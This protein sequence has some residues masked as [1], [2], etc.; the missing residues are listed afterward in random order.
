MYAWDYIQ[1][2][3]VSI[4]AKKNCLLVSLGDEFESGTTRPRIRVDVAQTS[5]FE[6]REFRTFKEWPTATSG[7]YVIKVVVP[8]N[9]ILH[10]LNIDA[11]EG[12]LRMLTK[13][14]GSEGGSFDEVFPIFSTN[15]MSE[16]PQ[17]P[18]AAQCSLVAGGTHTG[19]TVLDPLRVK[20]SGNTNFASSAGARAAERGIGAG[21]YYFAITLTNF[22]GTLK[23]RWEERP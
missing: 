12:S 1:K 15:T 23:A 14:G 19:G 5:F 3:F 7:E 21:T 10:E 20:T 13:V 9:T 4:F 18:Y 6:G 2:T 17:P 22:I 16:K 11:E 8:V